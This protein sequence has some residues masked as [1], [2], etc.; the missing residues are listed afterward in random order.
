MK[1]FLAIILISIMLFGL[2]GCEN[3]NTSKNQFTFS[4]LGNVEFMFA[5]GAGAWRTVL[6]IDEDGNFVGEFSD[7]EMGTGEYYLSNFSGRFSKLSNIT[8]W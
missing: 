4:D 2:V 8:E 1:K 6:R 5:S 7:A 3:T